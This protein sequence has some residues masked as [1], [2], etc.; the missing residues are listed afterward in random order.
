MSSTGIFRQLCGRQ[1]DTVRWTRGIY[2]WTALLS[3]RA[4]YWDGDKT[5]WSPVIPLPWGRA[6]PN[7][8]TTARRLDRVHG[9][10]WGRE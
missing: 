9:L 6:F 2:L 4:A 7:R 1:R 8:S 10:Q 5:S 3:C